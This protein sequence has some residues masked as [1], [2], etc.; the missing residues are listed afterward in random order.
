MS[1]TLDDALRWSAEGTALVRRALG[2]LDSDE[3]LVQPSALPGWTRKHVLAH[4][5][6]NADAIGNLV[7]WAK[8][9][10]E[11]PMYTSTTQ[12]NADI[13]AGA[14][15]PADE[16]LAWFDRSTD[17][18]DQGFD[19]LTDAEWGHE[20]VTAQGR[21]VPASEAP[22]MRTREVMVHAVDLDGGV[23]FDDLPADFLRALEED[24]RGKRAASG[25]EVPEVTGA[26]ADVVAWLAGR[27][28]GTLTTA[29]GGEAPTLPAWL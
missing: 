16:L 27:A 6:A 23:T 10:V 5:A 22:W 11:T 21:R 29:D 20:V 12:R 4:V 3:S 7:A 13:E 9:G 19:S 25:H 2:G 1:R 8:T 18:L 26:H 14:G 17:E 28:H 15:R 24:I